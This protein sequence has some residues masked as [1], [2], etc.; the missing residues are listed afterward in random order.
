M[1]NYII[2]KKLR[3]FLVFYFSEI[4]HFYYIT[5]LISIIQQKEKGTLNNRVQ[6]T[7]LQH[8]LS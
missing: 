5:F 8:R 2:F 6:C 7:L 3:Y 4:L 1:R